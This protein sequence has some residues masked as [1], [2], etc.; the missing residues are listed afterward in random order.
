MAHYVQGRLDVVVFF[1]AIVKSPWLSPNASEVE[2][3]GS[4]AF[5]YHGLAHRRHHG[6]VHVSTEHRVRVAR[7]YSRNPFRSGVL[8]RSD[9]PLEF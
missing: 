7:D 5:E 9:Y 8:R 1:L 2:P 3:E 4:H 6:V